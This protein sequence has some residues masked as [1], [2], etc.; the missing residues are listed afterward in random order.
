MNRLRSKALELPGAKLCCV[1]TSKP[2]NNTGAATFKDRLLFGCGLHT[3]DL[4]PAWS[5]ERAPDVLFIEFPRVRPD[6][7]QDP[8]RAV[9]VCNDLLQLARCAGQW[10]Q[11]VSEIK[12]P[13]FERHFR[14]APG[15]KKQTPWEIHNRRVLA[16][17]T[18]DERRLLDEQELPASKIHNVIDA[19]GMGLWVYGRIN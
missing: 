17:L 7:L 9:A 13:N 19:I 3:R 12:G 16:A 11:A 10:E 15:W 18:P 5:E 6:D 14:D 2:G 1:D 4:A 8:R